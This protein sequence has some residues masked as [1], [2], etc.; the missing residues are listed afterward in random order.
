MIQNENLEI[1]FKT[2][3]K[4]TI[5]NYF[6]N[7]KYE[8]LMKELTEELGLKEEDV[9]IMINEKN[10]TYNTSKLDESISFLQSF[11]DRLN[12]MEP[13]ILL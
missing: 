13:N 7:F 11:I 5:D 10:K 9:R 12:E 2:S 1:L 4:N 6:N 3:L 8:N